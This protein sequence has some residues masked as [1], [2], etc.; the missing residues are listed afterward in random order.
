MSQKMKYTNANL[1]FITLSLFV[2]SISFF[3]VF[4]EAIKYYRLGDSC[5]KKAQDFNMKSRV[6]ILTELTIFPKTN[7]RT[8]KV[9]YTWRWQSIHSIMLV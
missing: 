3:L 2:S 1:H 5:V 4:I 8:T 6:V 7:R 9:R